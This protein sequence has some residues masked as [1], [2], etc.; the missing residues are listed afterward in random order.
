MSTFFYSAFCRATTERLLKM[1][2]NITLSIVHLPGQTIRHLPAL[3]SARTR[4]LKLLGL[5]VDVYTRM[6]I[7]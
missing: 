2:D 5:S 3:M 6:T 4:N 1:F 7:N